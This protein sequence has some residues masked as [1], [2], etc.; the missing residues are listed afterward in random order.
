MRGPGPTW[1][2]LD[3]GEHAA[4]VGAPGA[5]QAGALA[6]YP[7][8]PVVLQ[9]WELRNIFEA[10]FGET[11]G[12][13]SLKRREEIRRDHEAFWCTGDFDPPNLVPPDPPITAKERNRFNTFHRPTTQLYSC[14]LP[15]EVV[16][17]CVEMMDAGT[18]DPVELL[19]ITE[20]I[21]DEFQDLNPMDLRFVHGMA[22]RG[23]R[24]FAVT[25]IRASTPSGSP[26]RRASNGS[27]PSARTPATTRLRTASAARPGC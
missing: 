10:E 11:H 5:A 9:R 15:G 6:A 3:R 8:D 16:A 19:G 20:L 24:V 22:E 14:V 23:A 25:T 7:A 18:L 21:V 26:R 1:R 27:R 17:R 13:G 4:L 12:I 2:R